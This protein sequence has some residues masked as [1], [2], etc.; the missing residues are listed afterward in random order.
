MKSFKPKLNRIALAGEIKIDKSSCDGCGKCAVIC[1][2]KVIS[3]QDLSDSEMSELSF[4][5]KVKVL[6]KGRRKAYVQHLNACT[7][8][9]LCEKNCHESA[10]Q[11]G[12]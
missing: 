9:R 12:N 6:F 8:C 2:N 7:S 5:G 1:P 4:K 11:V 10:I 3:L